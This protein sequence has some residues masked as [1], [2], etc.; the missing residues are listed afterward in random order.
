[1]AD[2]RVS[3]PKLRAPPRVLIIEDQMLIDNLVDD[4]VSE[5]GYATSGMAAAAAAAHQEFVK[6]NFDAVLLDIGL[7]VPYSPEIAD[8][9]SEMAIPFA[10]VTGYEG[11]FD[12]RHADVPLLRKPFT[13]DQLCVLLEKLVGSKWGAR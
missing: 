12:A 10:F 8:V 9:L 7:D 11:P 3:P 2:G 5:L 1:M 6:R 13:A 4:I